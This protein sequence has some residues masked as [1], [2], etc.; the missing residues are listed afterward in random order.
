MM[1]GIVANIA[2]PGADYANAR[3]SVAVLHEAGVPILAGTDANDAA[4]TP[5]ECPTAKACTASWNCW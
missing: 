3:A 5:R 1:A 4:G 2:P